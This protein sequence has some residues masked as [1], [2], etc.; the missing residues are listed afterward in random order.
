MLAHVSCPKVTIRPPCRENIDNSISSMKTIVTQLPLMGARIGNRFLRVGEFVPAAAMM[1]R[2]VS[3]ED[4]E[5]PTGLQ[6]L[7]VAQRA[8]TRTLGSALPLETEL[9]TGLTRKLQKLNLEISR[10][11]H[12]PEFEL[13]T[14]D[15]SF[16]SWKTQ[17]GFPAF[18]IFHL[19]N[20]TMTVSYSQRGFSVQSFLQERP[21]AVTLSDLIE[22]RAVA[23]KLAVSP[24]IPVIMAKH[25]L[26][27]GL[28]QS[29]DALCADRDL[30]AIELTAKYGG[31]MPDTV[32]EN[33]RK[34]CNVP[35]GQP[36]FEEILIVAEAPEESWKVKEI[37]RGDPL[38][39]GI[40]YGHLWLI[41]AFDLT[42]FETFARDLCTNSSK[43]GN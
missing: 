36:R 1:A 18:S 26:D 13:P 34:W 28:R 19:D 41:D 40:A 9:K 39:I 21:G 37:P 23:G 22:G 24:T 8:M 33:I 20:D 2:H 5:N 3:L 6:R 17:A 25:Y 11:E 14:L 31:V 7:Y 15:P 32:R 38:V 16:L 30:Q 10:F 42:P 12:T 4:L 43:A 29:L 35:S 27:D